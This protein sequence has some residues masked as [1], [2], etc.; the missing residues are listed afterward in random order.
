MASVYGRYNAVSPAPANNMKVDLIPLWRTAWRKMVAFRTVSQKKLE[1]PLTPEAL[2]ARI[3]AIQKEAAQSSD[4]HAKT[5][6]MWKMESL[7][8][9]F[10]KHAP[11]GATLDS[12]ELPAEACPIAHVGMGAGSVEVSEFD[13]DR[14]SRMIDSLAHRHYRLFGYESLGAMLGVYEKATPRVMLGLKPLNRPPDAPFIQAFPPEVQRLIAHGYGRLLYFNSKDIR[15][16]LRNIMKRQF[17]QPAAAVQGMAF[18][19]TMVNHNELDTVLETGDGL[20]DPALVKAFKAGLVYALAFW[21][22]TTPGF[23]PTLR[24]SSPR[25]SELVAIAREE[26]ASARQHGALRPFV[27]ERL[28]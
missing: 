7:G 1:G 16:T 21:E 14:I 6:A 27:V 5:A 15:S 20:P 17:L 19:Y 13:P 10:A 11:P 8:V 22:W 25:A 4:I 18:G 12:P 26:I 2:I 23:L 28:S 24:F 3:A 9:T